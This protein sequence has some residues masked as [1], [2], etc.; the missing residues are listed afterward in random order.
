[1]G[2]QNPTFQA[3]TDHDYYLSRLSPDTFLDTQVGE[4]VSHPC[5]PGPN[6]EHTEDLSKN[7]AVSCLGFLVRSYSPLSMV[8]LDEY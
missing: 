4:C 2:T 3:Q 1:M 5:S 7:C 8:K 6:K